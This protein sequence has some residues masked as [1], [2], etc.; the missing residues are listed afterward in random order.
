MKNILFNFFNYRGFFLWFLGYSLTPCSYPNNLSS[1]PL[2][3]CSMHSPL[4]IKIQN[5]G[6]H[7]HEIEIYCYFFLRLFSFQQYGFFLHTMFSFSFS[8]SSST[9][10]K[11]Y[12]CSFKLKCFIYCILYFYSEWAVHATSS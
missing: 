2:R 7:E 6:K 10:N 4:R 9:T 8:V 1:N 5:A 12:F 11:Q 3:T